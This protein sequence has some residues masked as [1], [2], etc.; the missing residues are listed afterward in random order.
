MKFR[1]HLIIELDSLISSSKENRRRS[2]RW[3]AVETLGETALFQPGKRLSPPNR[4][5]SAPDVARI[6]FDKLRTSPPA[7]GPS[8]CF[9]P[10]CLHAS[11]QTC[12]ESLPQIAI[13]ATSKWAERS[14]RFWI[15][16]AAAGGTIS[17][18]AFD[19]PHAR[20]VRRQT[21]TVS[22]KRDRR[23]ATPFD[24]ILPRKTGRTS[25]SRSRSPP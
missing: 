5:R 12:S 24:V 21:G 6:S 8:L 19:G 23:F 18:I 9:L 2:P 13:G 17:A 25:A 16:P 20:R 15:E 1:R 11:C 14:L 3:A 7:P 22:P 10:Q 4:A